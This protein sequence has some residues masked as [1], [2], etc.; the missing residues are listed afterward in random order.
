MRTMYLVYRYSH[1]VPRLVIQLPF[2]TLN[3]S[4]QLLCNTVHLAKYLLVGILRL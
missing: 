3:I 1:Q 2:I 4:P